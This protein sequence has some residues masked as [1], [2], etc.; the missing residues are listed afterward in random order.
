MII[1][2]N[3]LST[4]KLFPFTNKYFEIRTNSFGRGVSQ[5]AACL[6][7]FQYKTSDCLK[8]GFYVKITF[9]IFLKRSFDFTG[10]RLVDRRR[11]LHLQICRKNCKIIST[12][13]RV[14]VHSE[15][16]KKRFKKFNFLKLFRNEMAFLKKLI[17]NKMAL[18][19]SSKVIA[20]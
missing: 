9:K 1:S 2:Y 10:R 5:F 20:H 12:S 8:R 16:S 7:T 15:I 17:S 11:R 3:H 13:S 19:G 14:K 4:C 6:R 18:K